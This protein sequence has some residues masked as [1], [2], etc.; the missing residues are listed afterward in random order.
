M[1]SRAFYG[2]MT[3]GLTPKE[4]DKKQMKGRNVGQQLRFVMVLCMASDP[5]FL[6]G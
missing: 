5:V 1:Q 4:F 3:F 2:V 6:G